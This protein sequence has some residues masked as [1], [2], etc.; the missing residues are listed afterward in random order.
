[1]YCLTYLTFLMVRLSKVFFFLSLGEVLVRR[2]DLFWFMVWENV[3]HHLPCWGRSDGWQCS[4]STQ[5]L[6]TLETDRKATRKQAWVRKV[7]LVMKSQGSPIFP[8]AQSHLLKL[9]PPSKQSSNTSCLNVCS[10][11]WVF[12]DSILSLPLIGYV[13]LVIKNVFSEI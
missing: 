1:M 5:E 4:R 8:P 7:N 12:K 11:T 10:N 9:L 13:H 2:E 6:V 3:T